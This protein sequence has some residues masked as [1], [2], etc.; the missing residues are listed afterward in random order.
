MMVCKI[1]RKLPL[2]GQSRSSVNK[3]GLELSDNLGFVVLPSRQSTTFADI[4]KAIESDLDDDMF[5][6]KKPWKFYVPK[7]GPMSTKQ[8]GDKI[9]PALKFLTSTTDDVNLGRGIHSNPLKIVI[10]E[11][12][13]PTKT[14]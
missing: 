8:E 3:E 5:P 12:Y 1:L 4:R 13:V 6:Q 7:L 2:N 10:T 14:T 9:G 11:T